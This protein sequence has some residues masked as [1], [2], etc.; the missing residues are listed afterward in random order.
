MI[1]HA[2]AAAWFGMRE[3][4]RWHDPD[5][6]RGRVYLGGC[7]CRSRYAAEAARGQ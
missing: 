3:A 6:R 2:L 4:A 1:A 7:D 5:S